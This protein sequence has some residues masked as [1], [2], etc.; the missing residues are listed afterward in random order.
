[1]FSLTEADL[2]RAKRRYTRYLPDGMTEYLSN[3]SDFDQEV[4]WRHLAAH[5]QESID[6]ELLRRL[7]LLHRP[8]DEVPDD[9]IS[10]TPFR[11]AEEGLSSGSWFGGGVV[12]RMR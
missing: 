12:R 10:A 8:V 9:L 5:A 1:M 11:D 4:F 7:T 6:E 3:M 2:E